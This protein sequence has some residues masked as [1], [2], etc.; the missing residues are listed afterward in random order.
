MTS[1]GCELAHRENKKR[2][3]KKIII[4]RLTRR[5]TGRRLFDSNKTSEAEADTE[6]ISDL[7]LL[8]G[9]QANQ[10]ASVAPASSRNHVHGRVQ[11]MIV[12]CGLSRSK[13]EMDR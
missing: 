11:A 6:R 4:R 13:A 1:L 8:F 12:L 9:G 7:L 2:R 5:G 3:H 10:I